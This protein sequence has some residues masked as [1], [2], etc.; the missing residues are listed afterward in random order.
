VLE[1]AEGG[2]FFTSRRSAPLQLSI[3]QARNFAL[4]LSINTLM[5]I[6]TIDYFE[7]LQLSSHHELHKV[8]D[9]PNHPRHNDLI[10]D[11]QDIDSDDLNSFITKYHYLFNRADDKDLA[12]RE[13]YLEYHI[14]AEIAKKRL[15]ILN[16][17]TKGKRCAPY[18]SKDLQDLPIDEHGLVSLSDLKWYNFRLAHKNFVY[19]LSPSLDQCNS[20]HWLG[21]LIMNEAYRNG[22]KFKIRLDPLMKVHQDEFIPYMALMNLYG[23]KLE[24]ARLRTLKSEE[25]GQWLG[26]GLSTKSIKTTDYVWRPEG[27]EIHFTCE[28]LPKRECIHTR[29]S[30][31]F[32]AIFDKKSGLIK[33]CDGALR[34]YNDQELTIREGYHV[35]HP[36]V[37]KIGKRVKLFLIDDYIDQEL[38]MKLATNF[39][40]WNEDA[41]EYFN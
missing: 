20:S 4:C 38:F 21:L 6:R 17:F 32:H 33:H 8:M 10:E 11:L 14:A 27:N 30:R 15:S 18:D 37:R 19:Q 24:W 13:M 16:E 40:V 41:L 3:P 35:R 22:R 28:E 25:F 2:D 9:D 29:G 39:L 7:K 34:I 26:E 12:A 5:K 1:G 23:K 36:E 31:Y